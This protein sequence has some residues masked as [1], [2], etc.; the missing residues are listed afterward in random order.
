VYADKAIAANNGVASES[1]KVEAAMRG[2]Q[3]QT[4]RTG[5]TIVSA[6]GNGAN[7]ADNLGGSVRSVTGDLNAQ[8]A[9]LDALNAKY[10]QSN[11]DRASKY[12][13]VGSD[14]TKTSDGFEKNADGSAKGTFTNTLDVAGAFAL[15]DKAKGNKLTAA[16]L[17]SAKAAFKQ[18]QD[19][20]DYMQAI[21]KLNPGGQSFEF[22]QSTQ[23]LYV[24][25]RSAYEKV[26]ALAQA[27][28]NAPTKSTNPVANDNAGRTITINMDGTSTRIAVASEQDANNLEGLLQRLAQAKG[29][30][31]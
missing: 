19:A 27:E 28:K 22:V 5:K 31:R 20:L 6:M 16:D 9:A 11:A 4:D 17:D 21:G 26:Q 14:P 8:A 3:V 10:G 25:A 2:L 29:V 1:L 18:A 30:S 23:A 7:A 15:V 13:K 12:G 24:G